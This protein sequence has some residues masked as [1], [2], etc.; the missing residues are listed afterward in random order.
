MEKDFV[1]VYSTGQD[2]QAEIAREI[3]VDND[4]LA[5]VLNQQDSMYKLSHGNI[6]VYV[7]KDNK[8]KAEEIL[9]KLKN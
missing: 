9:K 5:V 7:H 6:E 1:I 8:V 4:I 2:F 3:L